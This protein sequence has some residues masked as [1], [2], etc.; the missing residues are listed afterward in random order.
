VSLVPE[1]RNR[2][3]WLI[4]STVGESNIVQFREDF[5]WVIF[6]HS[7]AFQRWSDSEPT[8]KKQASEGYAAT[9]ES[10][11]NTYAL[12]LGIVGLFTGFLPPVPI[13]VQVLS[14]VLTLATMLRI[15]TVEILIYKPPFTARDKRMLKYMSVWNRGVM[16]SWKSV[17]V[18]PVGV[19]IATSNQG[20]KLALW[21]IEDYV[22]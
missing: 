2:I 21:I 10:N 13:V 8:L 11:A 3:H 4:D 20:Y 15:A 19:L 18:I 22:D 17:L 1:Y 12:I 5:K 16:T 9:Q 14:L 7:K 6:E